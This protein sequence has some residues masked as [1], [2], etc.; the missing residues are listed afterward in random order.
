MKLDKYA[1]DLLAEAW[2]VAGLT[3][4]EYIISAHKF[5]CHYGV[6]DVDCDGAPVTPCTP[7]KSHRDMLDTAIDVREGGGDLDD[8]TREWVLRAPN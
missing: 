8:L 3:G 2:R 1:A 4:D 5:V 6:D 7:Y